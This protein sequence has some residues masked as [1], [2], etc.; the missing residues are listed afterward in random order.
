MTRNE[1]RSNTTREATTREI[2]EEYVFEEPDALTIPDSVQARFDNEEMSLRWIR[3]SVKGVDDIMNVGKKQQEGWI[4]VTPDEVP[5]MAITSFVREEGRYLGAV[6][7]GDLALA[8]KPT[9]KVKARQKFYENKANEQMD[10]VN[11]QLMK[12]SD[13]RMPITNTS[14]SVTTRGRQP[15][16]QD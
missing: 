10:A 7:R 11:A 15:S 16:F 9:A 3:I 4:F 5:E 2:E 13:S 14:K 6:C 8:K 12:S 1:I